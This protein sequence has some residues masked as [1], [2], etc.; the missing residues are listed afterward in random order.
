MVS[1]LKIWKTDCQCDNVHLEKN[2]NN[3]HNINYQFYNYTQIVYLIILFEC[4]SLLCGTFFC[5]AKHLST[6]R[7]KTAPTRNIFVIQDSRS[8]QLNVK[9]SRWGKINLKNF[10]THRI[11]LFIDLICLKYLPPSVH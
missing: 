8:L 1:I 10:V 7:K 3:M 5:Q 6:I 9:P 11:P 4:S 2:S